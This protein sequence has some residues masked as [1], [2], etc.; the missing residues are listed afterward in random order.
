M[1]NIRRK[2]CNRPHGRLT[3]VERVIIKCALKEY[4]SFGSREGL[5]TGNREHFNEPSVSIKGGE[6]FDKLSDYQCLKKE[7]VP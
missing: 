7:S 2:S 4:G 5:V 6:C 3:V 1:R